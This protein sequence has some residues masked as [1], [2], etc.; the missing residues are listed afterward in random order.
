LTLDD[1]AEVRLAEAGGLVVAGRRREVA[2]LG[3]RDVAALRGRRR[4]GDVGEE[5]AGVTVE[6]RADVAEPAAA[7]G[8]LGAIE[9]S[10]DS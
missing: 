4:R 9:G 1:G 3:G 6:Q 10:V 7:T 8:D 2:V 5:L